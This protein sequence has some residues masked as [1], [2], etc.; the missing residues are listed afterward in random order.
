MIDFAKET[1]RERV[2]GG[3]LVLRREIDIYVYGVFWD[4]MARVAVGGGE[5]KV[6]GILY[7]GRELEW[8]WV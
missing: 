7:D 4:G 2:R 8:V 1:R 3:G 6:E 5:L